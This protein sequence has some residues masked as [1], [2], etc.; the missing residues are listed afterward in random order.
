MPPPLEKKGVGG[1]LFRVGF[2]ADVMVN[3]LLGGAPETISSRLGKRKL[4][5]GGKLKWHDW[6]GLARP[7]DW[8]LDKIDRGHSLDAIDPH[9]GELPRPP[10]R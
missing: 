9:R 4:A 6:L 3:V 8:A 2:V 5:R 7:L 10:R 1:Y